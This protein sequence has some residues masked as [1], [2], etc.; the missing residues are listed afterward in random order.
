[1]YHSKET[2]SMTHR[3]FDFSLLAI[4]TLLMIQAS[5]ASYGLGIVRDV[6]DTTHARLVAVAAAAR[7]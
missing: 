6:A 2:S 5:I 7:R 1:M 3:R 4:A